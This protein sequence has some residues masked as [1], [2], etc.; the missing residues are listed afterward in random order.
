MM[1]LTYVAL[2]LNIQTV[3]QMNAAFVNYFS[4]VLY[5][6]MVWYSGEQNGWPSS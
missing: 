3:L 6:L 1:K 2:N 4:D 5:S